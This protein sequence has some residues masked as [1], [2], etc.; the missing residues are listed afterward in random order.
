MPSR[1]HHEVWCGLFEAAQASGCEE[2]QD[3]TDFSGQQPTFADAVPGGANRKLSCSQ[4]LGASCSSLVP[5][6]EHEE[7]L[8]LRRPLSFSLILACWFLKW[9]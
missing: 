3:R 2:K 4:E 7:A 8:R 1:C 6:A 5:V 9:C